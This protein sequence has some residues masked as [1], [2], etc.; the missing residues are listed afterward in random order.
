MVASGHAQAV[1]EDSLP[2]KGIGQP[3]GQGFQ[4]VRYRSIARWLNRPGSQG[5]GGFVGRRRGGEGTAIECR[6]NRGGIGAESELEGSTG[7]HGADGQNWAAAC[8]KTKSTEI[9]CTVL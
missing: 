3:P 6:G 2:G 9:H 8:K 4:E 7:R 5:C 1:K